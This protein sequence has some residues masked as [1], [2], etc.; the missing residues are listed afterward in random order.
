MF[1]FVLALSLLIAI[2]FGIWF[3]AKIDKQCND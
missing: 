1:Y 2:L 3:T